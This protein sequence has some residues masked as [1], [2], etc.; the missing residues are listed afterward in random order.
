MG[1]L[2]G[3]ILMALLFALFDIYLSLV[4]GPHLGE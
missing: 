1:L 3:P 2:V 4:R